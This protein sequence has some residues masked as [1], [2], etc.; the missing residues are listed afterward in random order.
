M[1]VY[2][3]KNKT[4]DGR[5]WYFKVYK[6]RKAYKSKR[7]MTKKEAQEEEALFIL[8]RDNP[9]HKQFILIATDYFKVF[10]NNSKPS[11]YNSYYKA[12][13]THIKSFFES[14]YA[15]SIDTRRIREWHEYLLNKKQLS[16]NCKQTNKKLSTKYLNKINTVLSNI[17]D[18][19]I[20]NY[21]LQ[22][23]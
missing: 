11:T 1:A 16:S 6:D 3:D 7:Y 10:S 2:K 18:F 14:D 20:K 15:D 23:I 22:V 9:L 8:K 12:Y 19:G 13:K 17:F 5:S 21:K 4:K